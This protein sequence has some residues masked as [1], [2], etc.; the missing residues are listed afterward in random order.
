MGSDVPGVGWFDGGG[1]HLYDVWSI[2]IG[3]G[4]NDA[5]REG[6]QEVSGG[7]CIGIIA[8]SRPKGFFLRYQTMA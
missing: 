3:C 5:R 8:N 6:S 4:E 2:G 7:S 1:N